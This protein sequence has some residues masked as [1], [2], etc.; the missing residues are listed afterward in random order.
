MKTIKPA[1]APCSAFQT[2]TYGGRVAWVENKV[3][4]PECTKIVR[5][6]PWHDPLGAQPVEV[7]PVFLVRRIN[8]RT[9]DWFF[10]CP[11]FPKCKHSKNR[12]KT[13]AERDMASRSWANGLYDPHH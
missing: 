9:N 8:K 3:T 6:L 2:W 11:N 1:V 7:E 12:P 4:C 13:N 5:Y 10:G